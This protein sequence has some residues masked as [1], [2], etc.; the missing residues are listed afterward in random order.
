[1][2]IIEA[3]FPTASPDD[4]DAVRNI[5]KE[6]AP[7]RAK[8]KAAQDALK[9]KQAALKEAEQKLQVVLD[10]VQ[11]LKDKYEHSTSKKKA[12]EDELADREAKLQRAE[13]L[14]NGLAGEKTRWEQSIGRYEEQIEAL[15][16]DAL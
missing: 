3:G 9:K 4:L 6:V 12:L 7:K 13:K 15:P 2:D 5:A 11:A 8:L 14:V 1:M 16:G 10:K